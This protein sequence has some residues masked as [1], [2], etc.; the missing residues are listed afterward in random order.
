ME[1]TYKELESKTTEELETLKEAYLEALHQISLK[2]NG[3]ISDILCLQ[4][5]IKKEEEE[6]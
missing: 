3:L 6:D 1:Y 4:V 2:K 5:R